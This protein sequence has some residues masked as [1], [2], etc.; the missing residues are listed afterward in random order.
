MPVEFCIAGLSP[1]SIELANDVPITP[2]SRGPPPVDRDYPSRLAENQS[3]QADS[4]CSGLGRLGYCS[5]A[6]RAE[7][8]AKASS[9]MASEPNASCILAF[10]RRRFAS[11]P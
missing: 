6:R 10:S 9:P 7:S 5:C 11:E 3:D 8:Q 1:R 4:A 2:A